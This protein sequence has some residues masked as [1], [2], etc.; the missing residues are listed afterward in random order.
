[1]F[2]NDA[3]LKKRYR[4]DYL[5]ERG[6]LRRHFH[7]MR[8]I[9]RFIA[10]RKLSAIAH[11][12]SVSAHKGP[13]PVVNHIVSYVWGRPVFEATIECDRHPLA[14]SWSLEIALRRFRLADCSTFI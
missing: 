7:S 4:R 14:I 5:R 13:E 3:Q 1:L 9:R 12:N 6:S 8:R 11:K 10:R 2:K